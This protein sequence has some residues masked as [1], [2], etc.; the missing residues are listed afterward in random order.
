MSSLNVVLQRAMSCQQPSKKAL[1]YS[2]LGKHSSWICV[3]SFRRK[4]ICRGECPSNWDFLL[5]GAVLAGTS[6]LVNE[7]EQQLEAACNLSWHMRS[8]A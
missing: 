8:E 5:E 1:L 3:V 6:D 4:V 2:R 7:A